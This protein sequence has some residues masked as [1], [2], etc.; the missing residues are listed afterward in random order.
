MNDKEDIT[1]LVSSEWFTEKIIVDEKTWKKKKVIVLDL[2][3]T[4]KE[5]VKEATDSKKSK[6]S[7]FLT[8]M[9]DNNVKKFIVYVN[10]TW[11]SFIFIT[12]L[13][14]YFFLNSYLQDNNTNSY[15]FYL[16]Y[17]FT[18]NK[19]SFIVIILIDIY[20]LLFYNNWNNRKNN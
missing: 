8:Q 2:D 12:S 9:R 17:I 3:E 7:Y 16:W 19:I 6:S 18:F 10:I 5:L 13:I 1:T 20:Y 14:A 4:N 15:I 11:F